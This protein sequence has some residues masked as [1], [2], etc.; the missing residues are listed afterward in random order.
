LPVSYNAPTFALLSGLCGSL[1][2]AFSI[3]EKYDDVEMTPYLVVKDILM[4]PGFSLQLTV[5]Q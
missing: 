4:Q 1:L 5:S 2:S 3:I